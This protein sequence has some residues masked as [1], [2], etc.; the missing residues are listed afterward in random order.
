MWFF[1][2]KKTKRT[3]V[4]EPVAEPVAH[5][6]VDMKKDLPIAYLTEE[7]VSFEKIVDNL[8]MA[9]F[10]EMKENNCGVITKFKDQISV[11]WDMI[12]VL[13]VQKTCERFI[14]RLMVNRISRIRDVCLHAG[15]KI[16][17]FNECHSLLFM[18]S[19]Y[20]MNPIPRPVPRPVK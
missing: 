17:A 12:H 6:V 8:A 19:E 7:E 14:I 16:E 9:I 20:V 11:I 3:P 10:N 2:K 15:S 5:H 13:M 18:W 4:A 1:F